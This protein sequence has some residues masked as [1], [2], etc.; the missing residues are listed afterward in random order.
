MTVRAILVPTD[1]S[2]TSE[3][4]LRY[5][6]QIA[7]T[8][9]AQLYLMHVPGRTGEHFE[10]SFPVG[11]FDTTAR[12]RLASFLTT[13]EIERLRPEY[14]LR[15]GSPADEIVRYADARDVDLII[16]GTHGRSGL[17]HALMGSVAEQIVR[18]A[19]CPVLVV[20][21]RKGAA[22]STQTAAATD[23]PVKAA[24]EFIPVP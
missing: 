7:L 18:T 23:A 22:V 5:A 19:P 2:E 24:R 12:A 8:L 15:T 11:G 21:S 14:A 9:G 17:A 20:R 1:F 6:A 13:Q 3:E 16:M 10:A 4:A